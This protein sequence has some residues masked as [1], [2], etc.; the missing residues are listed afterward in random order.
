ML[1]VGLDGNIDHLALHIPGFETVVEDTA[2][3]LMSF[4]E[5][6]AGKKAEEHGHMD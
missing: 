2:V 1:T 5:E 6:V 3:L 4:V